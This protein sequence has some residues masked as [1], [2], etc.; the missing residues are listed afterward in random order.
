MLKHAPHAA[1]LKI[2]PFPFARL[3]V[4]HLPPS[5]RFFAVRMR[6]LSHLQPTSSLSAKRTKRK[7]R[8]YWGLLWSHPPKL[9]TFSPSHSS[10]RPTQVAYLP[11]LHLENF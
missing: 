2:A 11:K 7:W 10:E 6:M 4:A 8:T 9:P 1:S 5:T 3:L